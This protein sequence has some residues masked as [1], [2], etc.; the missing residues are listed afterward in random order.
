MKRLLLSF[1]ALS[2]L[3]LFTAPAMAGGRCRPARVAHFVVRHPV[4]CATP[5]A[6]VV[7]P[8]APVVEPCPPP[9]CTPVRYHYGWH[10]AWHGYRGRHC[11]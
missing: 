11:R 6:P 10:R 4:V 9:V 1:V 2:C 7:T 8:C 5:C 3:G